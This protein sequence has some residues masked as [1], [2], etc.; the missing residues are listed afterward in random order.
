MRGT[1]PMAVSMLHAK[2]MCD[3][4]SKAIVWIVWKASAPWSSSS[5]DHSPHK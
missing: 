5:I 2:P 3:I 4:S 1:P